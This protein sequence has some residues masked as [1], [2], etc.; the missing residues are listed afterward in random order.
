VTSNYS[1][2]SRHGHQ[3][4]PSKS[5]SLFYHLAS[6]S[7]FHIPPFTFSVLFKSMYQSS[8]MHFE[9]FI[10]YNQIVYDVRNYTPA[11]TTPTTTPHRRTFIENEL[12]PLINH[13]SCS[14]NV[15]VYFWYS[16]VC[17]VINGMLSSVVEHPT[18]DGIVPV[19]NPGAPYTSA[20]SC[21]YNVQAVIYVLRFFTFSLK[22]GI[23]V[24]IST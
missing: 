19:S 15:T 2:A 20:N 6:S 18:A 17:R 21:L 9:Y 13:S 5:R 3:L 7:P 16:V 14:G 22:F 23:S 4:H 1:L 8:G 12:N 24:C 10:R 11:R